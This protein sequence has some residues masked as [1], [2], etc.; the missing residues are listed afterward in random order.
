MESAESTN[1]V[2]LLT[3]FI[4]GI[5]GL[6]V[7]IITW[8]LANHK[9]NRKFKYD[10]KITDYKEKR[11]LYV[12]LLASLDKIIRITESGENH[13]NLHEELSLISAR[14]RI[15]GSEN[16][17][18]KLFEISEI[19]FEWSSEYK[20]GSPKKLG[21]TN[22]SMIST[23]DS[24][25]IKRAN[26]LYPTLKNEINELARIIEKELIEIKNNLME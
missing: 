5:F 15:F 13:S 2:P 25:H 11:E 22:F 14:I 8:K 23:M 19:M 16:I 21:D 3:V 4:S 24:A 17:N 12:T 20:Q 26:E 1:L 9:E 7:A 18:N 10:Q 6:I